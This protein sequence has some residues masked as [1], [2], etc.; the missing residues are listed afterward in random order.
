VCKF[1]CFD[2]VRNRETWIATSWI[3]VWYTLR[4]HKGIT[5]GDGRCCSER[6]IASS[7]VKGVFLGDGSANGLRCFCRHLKK[8]H[9]VIHNLGTRLGFLGNRREISPQFHLEQVEAVMWSRKSML[10]SK[11]LP[12]TL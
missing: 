12:R 4:P 1:P 9:L 11:H 7:N 3:P 6:E 5:S 2:E 10:R 8:T